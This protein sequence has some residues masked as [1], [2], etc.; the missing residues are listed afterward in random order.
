[1]PDALT[2]VGHTPMQEFYCNAHNALLHSIVSAR[3]FV[4][5]KHAARYAKPG[6]LT[7][8]EFLS[9][10]HRHTMVDTSTCHLLSLLAHKM[11]G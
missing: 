6:A 1:V 10:M 11:L 8:Q 9:S 4:H 7:L 2:I 5:D 3:T